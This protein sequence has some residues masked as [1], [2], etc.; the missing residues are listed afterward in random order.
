MS[1]QTGTSSRGRD[2]G[3]CQSVTAGGPGGA[4]GSGSVT[5]F[6]FREYRDRSNAGYGTQLAMVYLV[7]IIVFVLGFLRIVRRWTHR[8][9]QGRRARSEPGRF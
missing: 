2:E 7:L 6:I 5:S 4:T 1:A 8:A 9:W 3:P